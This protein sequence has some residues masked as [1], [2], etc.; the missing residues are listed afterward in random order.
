MNARDIALALTLAPVCVAADGGAD[1]ALS[2]GIIPDAV[3]GD[4]DSISDHAR[5]QIPAAAIHHI[6]E[7]DSTDFDKVV[8][9]VDAPVLVAVGFTGG[10][11][12]HALSVLHGLMARANRSIVVL[13]EEDV[14]FLCPRRITLPTKAN[15]R[16]SLFPLA[17]VTGTSEGLYWPIAGLRFAPGVLSGTSNKATGPVTLEMDTPGM[18][19]LLPRR[20]IEPVVQAL[21]ELPERARWPALS[22][23]HRDPL[24]P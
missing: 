10:R 16:V 21:L 24:Q 19:C 13:G 5:V 22:A 11:M 4:L 15:D 12:D 18:L 1:A 14:V 2:A 7:Q 23:P 17:S 6:A 3:V 8:R 9:N 20:F